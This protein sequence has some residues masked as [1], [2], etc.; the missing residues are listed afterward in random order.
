MDPRAVKSPLIPRSTGVEGV[1]WRS[2]V[3]CCGA[4]VDHVC[5]HDCGS[6]DGGVE[7]C[8]AAAAIVVVALLLPGLAVI[9]VSVKTEFRVEE[10]EA[11]WPRHR[12]AAFWRKSRG[13]R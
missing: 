9:I 7:G 10:E 4:G 1:V 5:K 3:N 2:A 11:G 8:I 6:I 13:K 12:A